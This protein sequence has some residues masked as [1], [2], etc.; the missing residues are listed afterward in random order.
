M[1]VE[2]L[3]FKPAED[4]ENPYS[5]YTRAKQEYADDVGQAKKEAHHWR[6]F[7][8][9]TIILLAGSIWG[10]IY[11]SNKNTI[12]P[13][14]IEIDNQ[15]GV[16]MSVNKVI[17]AEFKPGDL[18]IKNK[19]S[20]FIKNIRSISTDSIVVRENYQSAYK[21]LTRRC[22]DIFIAYR[23]KFKP[24]SKIGKKAISVDNFI[25]TKI[26]KHSFQAEWTENEFDIGEINAKAGQNRYTGTFTIKVLK[27][28]N[29]EQLKENPLGIYIDEF[30]IT[31]KY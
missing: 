9:V 2:R 19:I 4:Y 18:S 15:S 30:H 10:N 27:V 16:V 11:L 12:T 8:F 13:Y 21:M 1:K 31:K 26:T 14:V 6:I 3:D 29:E 17:S 25:I 5:R 24:K 28:K 20:R 7:A 22:R 23:D